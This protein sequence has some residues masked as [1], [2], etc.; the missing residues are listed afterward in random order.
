MLFFTYDLERYRDE[1][2]GF[3]FDFAAEAPGPLLQTN[4]E[5]AAALRDLDAVAAAHAEPYRDFAS[6]FCELDDG[7]SAERVVDRLFGVGEAVA[8]GARASVEPE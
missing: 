4:D 8:A 1:I 6:T 2:R 3:Y 5:L 7:R